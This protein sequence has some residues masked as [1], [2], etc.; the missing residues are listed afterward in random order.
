MAQVASNSDP[1]FSKGGGNAKKQQGKP[2][3]ESLD[4]M[5]KQLKT[6]L[7]H[8]QEEVL[9]RVLEKNNF[10]IPKSVD[11]IMEGDYKSN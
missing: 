2:T 7:P 4:D 6:I 11:Y 3:R 1:K 10:D 9:E 8:M 5:I